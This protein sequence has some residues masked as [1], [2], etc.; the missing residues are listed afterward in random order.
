MRKRLLMPMT[1]QL[2]AEKDED[3]QETTSTET[4]AT[5]TEEDES[6]ENEKPTGKTFTRDEVAKM[7]ATETAKAIQKVEEQRKAEEDEAEKLAKMDETEKADYEKQKLEEELA[8]YKRKEQ[9]AKMSEQANEMLSEKGAKP[10][11]EMLRLI[12]TE[13]AETTSANVKT[14]LASIEEERA[15]IKAD[16]ERRLGG[17]IPLDTNNS[18]NLSP[19]ALLA[20]EANDR[21]KNQVDIKDPWKI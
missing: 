15:T 11:K 5:I 14:Y 21:K 13:D 10:T 20:K 7:I 2:F 1:L 12:V 18:G 8:E 17:R 9:L 19:G 16:F 6:K 3:S 4:E